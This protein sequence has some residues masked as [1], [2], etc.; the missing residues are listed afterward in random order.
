MFV[1][2]QEVRREKIPLKR[3]IHKHQSLPQFVNIFCGSPHFH[4]S[5]LNAEYVGAK[6]HRKIDCGLMNW[7]MKKIE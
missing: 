7:M 1:I 3:N 5:K 2:V 4:T 6:K